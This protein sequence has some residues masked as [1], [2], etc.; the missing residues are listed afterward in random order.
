MERAL[1]EQR[2]SE[3]AQIAQLAEGITKLLAGRAV[4]GSVDGGTSP[5][6][7]E[8]MQK[9]PLSSTSKKTRRT[10]E[11]DYP[12]FE[13]EGDRLI[14]VGWSKKNKA[15]YEH[16]A[17]FGT[18]IAFAKH[19]ATHASEGEVFAMEN[20]LPVQDEEGQEI[21]DYQAY[22]TLAWLRHAGVVRKKGRDGYVLRSG[23]SIV[24]RIHELW[25]DL[26]QR[27]A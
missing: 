3:V 7:R 24:E 19:L 23:S 4:A 9:Q 10:G 15:E 20:L 11:R 2:Y 1:R 14:K 27:P 12:R 25:G 16:R 5:T 6:S 26:N 17:S 21:P 13:R 8:V 18:V 22:L